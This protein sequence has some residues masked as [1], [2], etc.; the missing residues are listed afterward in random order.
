MHSARLAPPQSTSGGELPAIAAERTSCGIVKRRLLRGAAD[1]ARNPLRIPGAGNRLRQRDT[2]LPSASDFPGPGPR[3]I[4][5]ARHPDRQSPRQPHHRLARRR[6]D[7][8]RRWARR[9]RCPRRGARC[10]DPVRLKGPPVRSRA[11]RSHR[12]A[13]ALLPEDDGRSPVV[14]PAL[15]WTPQRILACGAIVHRVRGLR[16]AVF[17]APP[18][19]VAD[20]GAA[21]APRDARCSWSA[22][23]SP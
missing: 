12:P 11:C 14:R 23:R 4:L 13:S 17:S 6:S 7:L 8:R 2:Q 1:P 9:D 19:A 10:R 22:G 5:R 15:R 20:R 18:Q 21:G 16:Y 3:G